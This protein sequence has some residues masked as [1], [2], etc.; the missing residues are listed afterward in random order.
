MTPASISTLRKRP[1]V[2]A[3]ALLPTV[4]LLVLGWLFLRPRR[5]FKPNGDLNVILVT[6]DTLRADHVGAYGGGRAQTPALD[7]LAAEGA[8]FGHCVCQT[9]LT[10]PSH[11][12]LLSSTYPQFNQVRDNGGF[13]APEALTLLSEALKGKGMATA[14][15]IGAFVLHGKGGRKQGFDG[16]SDRFDPARYDRILLEH[17]SR[18]GEVLADARGWLETVGPRPFFA[19]IHLYDPHSP[20]DPPEPYGR[21]TPQAAY[22]GEVEYTDAELGK[23][24]AFLKERGIYD[25]S[26]IVVAADHGEGLGDHDEDGHGTFLYETTLHVPL[27]FRAPRP[28]RRPLVAR[29]VELVDVAPTVLDLL[30]VPVPKGWQ[31]KSLW[32]LLDG[33]A[34]EGAGQ[35]YSETYYPRFHYGWSSLRSF[36]CGPLKYILAPRDELYDLASDPQELRELAGDGRRRGLR[37][38]L[39]AFVNR[40]SRGALRP[41]A[42]QRLSPEDQRRLAALG[43]LSGE[44]KVDETRPLADPKDKI[45]VGNALTRATMLLEE[46]R[47][48]EAAG[49]LEGLTREEPELADAWSLQGNV[50]LKLGRKDG[51]LAS[52][53]RALEL[54]PDNLFLMLNIV[55]TL[56]GSGEAETAAAESLRFLQAF[57]DE[58]TLLEKLGYVRLLQGR[59]DEALQVLG[60]AKDLDPTAPQLANLTAEALMRKEDHAGA[61]K[62]L[63]RALADN[64]RTR[65]SHYLM[66]QVQEALG[67][68][69]A[70]RENYRQ[71]LEINPEKYQAAVNLANLLKQRGDLD[72]AARFYRQALE[73]EPKLKMP[74]FHLAEILL[75]RNG[76]LQQAVRLCLE[77]VAMPPADRDTLFGYYVL[78][79]LYNAL[80]ATERRDFYTREGEKLIARL[81][82]KQ[83]VS[84]SKWKG[85]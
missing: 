40:S 9:P 47:F 24:I 55:Q 65:N 69:D 34:A 64:P 26:L 82:K 71:E 66:A 68:P 63:E 52:F 80:G 3:A 53:R 27:I 43:Y 73:A 12:S 19:W 51:A 20:Y 2:L 75:R 57:P 49:I 1:A 85:S 36:S 33:R 38:Q 44:V 79:N 4:F 56:I 28:F 39:L 59:A 83:N 11:T 6:I 17:A 50:N 13:R 21:G 84:N 16:Y 48:A 76:D 81:E 23:F 5:F 29:T 7:T 18:A 32:P 72:D 25:R 37:G 35:G 31:G 41:D 67:R 54:K 45:A 30:R 10:L 62:I 46:K 61:E 78:T 14:A 42:G 70:A 58:P 77:G 60:R 8:R 22:R 15:F 74:R